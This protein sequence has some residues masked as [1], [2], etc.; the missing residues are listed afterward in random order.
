M[1]YLLYSDVES[2]GEQYK[3]NKYRNG[4]ENMI[5]KER[6]KEQ[7][8]FDLKKGKLRADLINLQVLEVWL[9]KR[10]TILCG[11]WGQK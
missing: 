3:I 11:H 6:L 9:E 1:E 2:S 10:W 5:Y 4:L 7:G 8:L